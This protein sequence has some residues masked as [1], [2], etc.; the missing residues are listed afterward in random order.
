MATSVHR[1]LLLTAA[2]CALPFVV[3]CP[4]KEPPQVVEATPPPEPAPVDA[5]VTVLE[6]MEDEVVAD[7]AAEASAPKKPTGTGTSTNVLRVKQC[8]A[9]LR[10]QAKLLGASPEAGLLM[11][12]AVQCDTLATQVGPGGNAPELGVVRGLLRGRTLPAAC[13]SF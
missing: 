8:C 1:S 12:A 2:F 5:A 3:G 10:T 13:A 4:K 11:S 9:Q 6:P 7:A